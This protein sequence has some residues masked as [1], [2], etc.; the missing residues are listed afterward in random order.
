MSDLDLKEDRHESFAM[1][2]EEAVVLSKS[3]YEQLL[4]ALEEAQEAKRKYEKLLEEANTKNAAEILNLRD[5][6]KEKTDEIT[7]LNT[8]L[9][10]KTSQIE[11]L[12]KAVENLEKENENEKKRRQK[13]R[14]DRKKKEEKME[15]KYKKENEDRERKHEESI[16]NLQESIAKMGSEF[17]RKLDESTKKQDRQHEILLM[18][19]V[20]F[21]FT[22]ALR[23]RIFGKKEAANLRKQLNSIELIRKHPKTSEQEEIFKKYTTGLPEDIDATLSQLKAGRTMIAHPVNISGDPKDRSRPTPRQLQEVV[24]RIY[25]HDDQVGVR[26]N[27]RKIIE[28]LDLLTRE[29]NRPILQTILKS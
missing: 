8:Q 4:K 17:D 29:L 27:I 15:A 14:E 10:L 26:E 28:N 7:E 2:A 25:P 5:L 6:I 11:A 18:G 16:R 20:A 19:S 12:Q 3:R 13:E 22:D 9:A 23:E 24:D 1:A 21:N